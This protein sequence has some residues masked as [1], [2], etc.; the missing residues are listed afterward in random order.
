MKQ[1]R[2]TRVILSVVIGAGEAAA[3][4]PAEPEVAPAEPT[5]SEDD[6]A[7]ARAEMEARLESLE[8]KLKMAEESKKSRFPIKI[9]GYGDIG[10]FATQGDGTGVRQDFAHANYPEYGNYAWVF[11]G[12]LLSTAVNSRGE[13]ADLG[14][15]PGAD[16]YDGINSDGKPSFL[17]NELNLTVNAGLGEH[18]LFTSSVNFA[19][20]TGTDFRLGDQVDIDVV[21]VEYM[22]TKDGKTSI[23]AGKVDS[24][25]GIEYKTRKANQK[26]GITPSL[27]ARYTTGTAVGIKARTKLFNDHI[28]L[29]A[30]VTNSTFV[31][32]QFHFYREIDNNASKMLSGRA[33]FRM[34][35]GSGTFEVGPSAQWGTQDGAPTGKIWFVGVDAE[36]DVSRFDIKAQWLRGKSP[37]DDAT[38]TY[39]LDLRNGGYVEAN[40]IITPE[41]GVLGRAEFRDADVAL[42]TN[43][44]YI[45]K[46]WRATAGVR[47][48]LNP[49]ATIKAEYLH[50][51]TYGDMPNI[52]DDVF[53]ASAVMAF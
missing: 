11:Y 36:L 29:A 31:T 24:V 50:N 4:A 19:P 52:P 7:E 30:A 45:T 1:S 14:D 17:V 42:T 26:F 9:S 53:T 49:H 37:G 25:I 10:F 27:I 47:F 35:V 13:V 38:E 48:V 23:F 2:L 12:D 3:Q 16:R 21:Q 40:V 44:L 28:V 22:P 6:A 33:A 8:A 15:L 18:A 46:N 51:G 32:E 34:P 43:R 20:R 39:S 5:E 41:I